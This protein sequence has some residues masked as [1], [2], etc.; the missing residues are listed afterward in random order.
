MHAKMDPLLR[1]EEPSDS[2]EKVV[3]KLPELE[4]AVPSG[5]RPERAT[6][7]DASADRLSDL[8]PPMG[9]GLEAR[10]P[11]KGLVAGHLLGRLALHTHTH[12][13]SHN[14][15]QNTNKKQSHTTTHNHPPTAQSHPHAQSPTT[16][17]RER[18]HILISRARHGTARPG[19]ARLG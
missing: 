2:D 5:R 10:E 12:T 14:T 18:P 1:I 8:P 7:A 13:Q 17:A 4:A 9:A 19:P 16:W 15:T 11:E 6:G 3:L